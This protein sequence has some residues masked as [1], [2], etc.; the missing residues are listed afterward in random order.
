MTSQ[1]QQIRTFL[2]TLFEPGDVFEVRAPNTLMSERSGFRSTVSGYF[3]YETIDRAVEEIVELDESGRAPGI[4]VTMNPVNPAL[5][6]R[7]ADRLAPKAQAT[8]ADADILKR[9]W[10]VIDFDPVRP[11]GVSASEPE[12]EKAH[13]RMELIRSWLTRM[14]SPEPVAAMSGNGYHLIYRVDLPV[15]DWGIVK[16]LLSHMSL[17]YDD[18]HVAIDRTMF[19]PARITKVIGTMARKGDHV[20]GVGEVEDRPHRRSYL[21]ETAA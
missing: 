4:Y 19:N 2:E 13:Q 8:T 11:S 16:T 1:A 17:V 21:L 6:A 12:L 5:L 14:N 20:V 15:D 9:R 18:E 10:M 3:R 7:A